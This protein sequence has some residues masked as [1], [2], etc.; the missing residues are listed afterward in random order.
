M[1]R[2]AARLVI[3][4]LAITALA[5]A[6]PAATLAHTVQH[7][8]SYTLE[9][10]WL[11]EPTYVGI[12]NG[13]SVTV[14]DAAGKPVTDLGPDDLHVVVTTATQPSPDLAFEPV[15]DPVEMNGPLG[16]YAA[17]IEPTAPGDYT[18]HLTGSVHGTKVEV[19]VTSG[20]QT[21]DAVK[22]STDL[23]FPAKLPSAAE[24]STRLD[25]IDARVTALGGGTSGP[26]QAAVD[27]ASAAA[28]G[29][30]DTADFALILGASL[31]GAG[32]VVGALGLLVAWR[33]T[34]KPA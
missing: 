2:R 22:E 18:F 10:G 27:A 16:E 30:K 7:A 4:S 11:S 31:G 8:G 17:A 23:Q 29:A 9:I 5:I 28:A 3:A 26:S 15:F 32:L 1:V 25:R 6:A 13:V 19:T 21:F 34:R 12:P 24:I 20:D 14:T 33:A